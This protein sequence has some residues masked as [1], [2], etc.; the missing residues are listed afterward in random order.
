M[1]AG[2]K[3][4]RRREGDILRINLGDGRH[5]YAQVAPEPLIVFFDGAYTADRPMES[6]VRLPVLFRLWVM[7]HAMTRA[8]WPVIGHGALAPENAA[9]PFFYKQDAISGRLS[10]Y[11]S[12]FASTNWERPASLTE[13]QGL[14]CAAVWEPEHVVDRLRDHFACRPNRWEESLKINPALVP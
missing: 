7:N 3:R 6:V 8:A 10:L 14:E 2:S 4:V 5:S 9:E 13:C 12:T 1:A 11:H